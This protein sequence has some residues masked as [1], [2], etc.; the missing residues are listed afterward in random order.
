MRVTNTSDISLP[1][2]VWLLHD[3][4]DYINEPN[5][6]SVTRLMRP[7]RQ[8]VL[9][10]RVPK[11]ETEVDVADFIAR[12][13]GH[14]IHDSIEKAWTEGRYVAALRMLGYPNKV[15]ASVLVNP[16]PEL[17]A[18]TPN[19]IPIYVEQRGMRKIDGYTIG[20][21]FDMV[22]D[23]IVN[24]NKSTSVYSWIMGTRDDEH[25]LQGSLYRWIQPNKITE[26]FMRIH[27][28]FTDWSKMMARS[29][30]KYPKKRVETKELQLMSEQET[31]N[32]I[33]NRLRLIEQYKDAPEKDIPE[34]TDEELW[35]S[36][37]KYKY[38]SDPTKTTG[39][40][41][42]NFDSL[43][44]ANMHLNEKNKGIVITVPGEVKR[45]G[46]CEAFD[47]CGQKDRYFNND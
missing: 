2:A 25:I 3:D 1:L 5:Y 38:Y 47:A 9:G 7:L 23:G 18:A 32:W 46:Y 11:E 19:A 8:I 29:Q 43:S 26:D 39:R 13:L 27:Y 34:C 40:S 31:E 4:Y 16:T 15:I 37:P 6:I 17:L 33:R 35:R 14:A 42:R 44:E 12:K 20:G 30:E 21:K 45:C 36:D 41:T 22:T 10:R 28:I 24:D